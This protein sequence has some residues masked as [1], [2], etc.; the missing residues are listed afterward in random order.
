MLLAFTGITAYGES[1]GFST[2]SKHITPYPA[3]HENKYTKIQWGGERQRDDCGNPI[4]L[5]ETVL[6][7]TASSL[8][9]I[10][11]ADGEE[12]TAIELPDKCST[13]YSGAVLGSSLLLPTERGICLIDTDKMTI[14][15]RR[16]FEGGIVSDCAVMDKLGY[17][18]VEING[19]Y[20][21]LCVDLESERLD[22]VWSVS[23]PSQPSC[24]AVQG[25]N[26]IFAAGSSIFTHDYKSD[27]FC[28]IPVGKEITGDPFATEYAVFFSTTDGYSGKL[29]LNSDGTLEEDT[30]T[31]CKI[32]AE[33]SSPV[34]WNG[35]LYTATKDG[36]Y[37][38]DDL[39]M[40]VSGIISEINGGY[41]PQIH[42]GSG[43]YIYTVA[44]RNDR[45]AVYCILDMDEE[46]QP[47]VN[48]I[49]LL[50]Y[51]EA[52]SFCASEKGS[53]Y[54]RDDIGRIYSLTVAPF[55]LFGLIIRLVVILALLA[56]V[57]VW[58]KKVAK[59]RENLR[60]RY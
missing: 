19:G 10:N 51:F 58:I 39:N 38:L 27:K 6:L 44:K 47:T 22:T 2:A 35:R 23:V 12:A 28:E 20:E 18:S 9:V 25:D 15:A 8:V 5:G 13:A 26:I 21:L 54:F 52:G 37:I 43:P 46:T 48:I 24:A 17:V 29:R 1:A 3:P 14:N 40:E 33:P 7:P 32:G 59:R 57:F 60:P 31:F 16:G 4:A 45:W 50:D 42:Y 11:E 55:D 30:L 56:L 41:T 34:S 49:A 36:F 53:L